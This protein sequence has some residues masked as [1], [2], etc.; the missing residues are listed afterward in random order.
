MLWGVSMAGWFSSLHRKFLLVLLPPVILA[1][2]MASAL[3]IGLTIRDQEAELAERQEQLAN[4]Y[5]TVLASALWSFDDRGVRS[6]LETIGFDRD[7]ASARVTSEDRGVVAE[8]GRPINDIVLAGPIILRQIVHRGA[9]GAKVLGTLRIE[10][11]RTRIRDTITV[12]VFQAGLM[13]IL[14]GLATVASALVVNR[15]IVGRPLDRLLSAIRGVGAQHLRAPIHWTSE[16]EFGRVI[17]AF[18]TM[19]ARLDVQ[20]RAQKQSEEQLRQILERSPVAVSIVSAGGRYLWLNS[21]ATDILGYSLERLIGTLAPAIYGALKSDDSI[22]SSFCDSSFGVETPETESVAVSGTMGI[23]REGRDNTSDVSYGASDV[24]YGGAVARVVGFGAHGLSASGLSSREI[25]Y[26]RPDGR[27]TWLLESDH[28]MNF[29]GRTARIIWGTDITEHKVAQEALRLAKDQAEGATRAK[30]TF[31][32]TMSHEIRTPMNGVMS[33]AEMLEQTPLSVDQQGMVAVIRDSASALLTI[34]ND[35]LDFSKIEAGRLALEMV[36]MSLID[37]VEGVAD[38]LS[39][40]VGEKG[41]DLVVSIDPDLPDHRRGDPIR[42]RQVLLNL[43]GNA[44]KFTESGVVTILVG[45]VPEDIAVYEQKRRLLRS[46]DEKGGDEALS[47][48]GRWTDDDPPLPLRVR[49]Q[50]EDTGPGLSQEDQARLFT[51]FMQA[52]ASTSRRYGGTGLGLSICRRLIEIMGGEIGVRSRSGEG[53]TFWFTAPLEIL[54]DRRNDRQ[55]NLSQVRIL[56]VGGGEAFYGAIWPLLVDRGAELLS[57]ADGGEALCELEK[58][59]RHEM[60]Y[61]VVLIDADL[62]TISGVELSARIATDPAL[63]TTRTVLMASLFQASTLNEAHRL[64]LFAVVTKPVRRDRL[65]RAV[66]AAVGR[67]HMEGEFSNDRRR[68]AKWFAPPRIEEARAAG[69][70]ILVA[71][72]NPTNQIVI[73]KLLDRLGYACDVAVNGVD[74]LRQLAV[75]NYG[76]L[77]TDCHMPSMDGYELARVIRYGEK[78]NNV[79]RLPIVALTADVMSGTES[80]CREAGMDDY[81]SKPIEIGRLDE[82]IRR[83]L[84][85]AVD[86]RVP[87]TAP[88]SGGAPIRGISNETSGGQAAFN[89]NHSDSILEEPKDSFVDCNANVDVVDPDV[90]DLSYI[91]G[92]FGSLN[93]EAR[94]MLGFFIESTEPLL[95]K[96]NNALFSGDAQKACKAAHAALG[97]A[98]SVGGRNLGR[99]LAEVEKHLTDGDLQGGRN[100][101]KDVE[102]CFGAVYEQISKLRSTET[103]SEM[104]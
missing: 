70:L 17:E 82:T 62:P 8:T 39:H 38:V 65:L 13:M 43:A 83:W 20:E 76:M 26:Q 28:Q 88:S 71:E 59:V 27:I 6:I 84:P 45:F 103:D 54:H 64:H 21:R 78:N 69:A 37:V 3:F 96:M 55:Y 87:V 61:H 46:S 15:M 47:K 30:S 23:T 94:D 34:I 81:L 2:L 33:M 49:F 35:I 75:K 51:P 12:Q 42:L 90:L 56:V 73:R 31:L 68:R 102:M 29:E 91:M 92:L 85:R 99:A 50:V 80:K 95:A 93:N 7:V 24:S 66:T 67:I 48:G 72:D 98:R 32:A 18:N 9:R 25:A 4:Y 100:S 5:S 11:Q 40:Q 19:L 16:D 79:R 41:I 53:A 58:A 77:L 60:P 89:E 52:D 22:E 63:M 101:A 14:L 1:T 74:A 86:L 104:K 57:A 97:A 36:G 44:V 10:F